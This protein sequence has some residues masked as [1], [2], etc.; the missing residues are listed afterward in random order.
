MKGCHLCEQFVH[1]AT[2]A[3]LDFALPKVV[4]VCKEV[5]AKEG[6]MNQGLQDDI[7][8]TRLTKVHQATPTYTRVSLYQR[9]S[10]SISP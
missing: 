6:V 3:V 7:E 2:G 5:V 9:Q 8:V 10:Q 1:F 4:F